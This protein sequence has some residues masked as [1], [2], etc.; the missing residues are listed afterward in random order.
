M[1][2]S[3]TYHVYGPD[4]VTVTCNEL[5]IIDPVVYLAILDGIG[6][7]W[8]GG[9]LDSEA[10]RYHGSNIEWSAARRA[11]YS[12]YYAQISLLSGIPHPFKRPALG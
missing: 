3:P 2:H 9:A 8:T 5:P 7:A 1:V 4:G 12:A 10:Y 6:Q 11:Y